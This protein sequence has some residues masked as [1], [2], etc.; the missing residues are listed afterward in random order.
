MGARVPQR[1][2]PGPGRA[3]RL[4]QLPL[5]HDEVRIEDD[6][7]GDGQRLGHREGEARGWRQ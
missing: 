7:R 4:S 6:E 5:A 2:E 3:D 1:G